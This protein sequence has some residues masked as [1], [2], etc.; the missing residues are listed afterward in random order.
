[1]L[2][3]LSHIQIRLLLNK[4]AVCILSSM[5]ETTWRKLLYMSVLQA[6]RRRSVFVAERCTSPLRTKWLT[7]S[8]APATRPTRAFH[9]SRSLRHLPWDLAE[10]L[11]VRSPA[12]QGPRETKRT[13]TQ[14]RLLQYGWKGNSVLCRPQW[15]I[16]SLRRWNALCWL[17]KWLLLN[18]VHT[19]DVPCY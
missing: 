7:V 11:A 8:A 1:M 18:S 10:I 12:P 4:L 5:Q 19:K 17:A 3:R 2:L 13:A 6:I 9:S 16:S 14:S 15:R